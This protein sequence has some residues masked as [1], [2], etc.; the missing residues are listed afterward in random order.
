[1]PD[2]VREDEIAAIFDRLRREVREQPRGAAAGPGTALPIRLTARQEAERLWPVTADRPLQKRAGPSE[3]V[4]RP[5][6]IV[7]R[8]A[9]RWYVE[10]PL[11]DQRDFNATV[12]D[13]IDDL[14][15][16]TSAGLTRLERALPE[17]P[18]LPDAGPYADELRGLSPVLAADDPAAVNGSAEGSLGAVVL[19]AP[20]RA[21]SRE[22]VAA[23]LER[24]AA[25]L[26]PGGVLVAEL[27][28]SLAAEE[29]A[30]LAR[31]AGFA[32][33]DVR[34]AAGPH[35]YVLLARR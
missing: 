19:L 5:V 31:D 30:G 14:S 29:A 21:P 8:K 12:L 23:A 22:S 11:A 24:T 17:A 3:L 13:L 28:G 25:A 1:M 16:R 35:G 9:M 33:A 6:R 4:L 18:D 32:R 26:R 7:L 15:E 34:F 27:G 2:A 10:P 20:D